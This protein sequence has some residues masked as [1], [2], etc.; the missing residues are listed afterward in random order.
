MLI[1]NMMS[2]VLNNWDLMELIA[3]AIKSVNCISI[4]DC[5]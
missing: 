4:R 3:D 5:P 1:D 2:K